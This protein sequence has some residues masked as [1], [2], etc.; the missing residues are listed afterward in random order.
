LLVDFGLAKMLKEPTE[1]EQETATALTNAGT[2]LGTPEYLSPEQAVGKAVDSRTDIY[3]LGVVLFQMLTGRVPF[4]GATPVMTVIQHT[5]S[6]PPSVSQLNPTIPRQVEDVILKALAK[7][8]EQRYAT[9]G[10][11][12]RALRA[13]TERRIQLT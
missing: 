9:A 1:A 8:P 5:M 12:V 6:T 10:D 4:T 7:S 2:I 3:S 11:F 13:A